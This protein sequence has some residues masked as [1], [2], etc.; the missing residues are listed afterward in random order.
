MNA[1]WANRLIA[2]DKAWTDV[3]ANRKNAVKVILE[4]RVSDGIISEEAYAAI[5]NESVTEG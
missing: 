1:I 5:V 2:G 4:Q 3:P